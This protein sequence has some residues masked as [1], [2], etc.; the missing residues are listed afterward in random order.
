MQLQDICKS[1]LMAHSAI[2]QVRSSYL[3]RAARRLALR[4]RVPWRKR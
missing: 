1:H 4:T 2:G 3:P